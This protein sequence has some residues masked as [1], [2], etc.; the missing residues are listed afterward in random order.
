MKTEFLWRAAMVLCGALAVFSCG[1]APAPDAAVSLQP[2]MWRFV[3]Q[4]PGGELPINV[5]VAQGETGLTATVHNGEERLPLDVVEIDGAAVKLGISHY[6][7]YFEG[8]LSADGS[9]IEGNWWKVAGPDK[10]SSL[11]FTATFGDTRRFVFD[12]YGEPAQVDGRWAVT[13]ENPGGEPQPA[14]GVFE[15]EGRIV[16]GTF[17][18]PVG[19][20]RFLEG[21]VNG[22]TLYLSCF[23]GGH[24]FLFQAS[25][26]DDG[27][28]N[29]TFWSRDTWE[30]DW[31]AVRDEDVELADPYGMLQ[32]KDGSTGFRFAFPNLDGE[33]VNQDDPMFQGKV[34]L[35]SVF[36]SWCPNCNDEA[37]FLQELYETYGDRGLVVLGLAFE[38][39]G[40]RERDV[41][42]LQRFKKR[43]DL[44]YPVLLAGGSTDKGETAAALPDLDR[45]IAY[46]TTILVDRDG[47]VVSIHTGFS[48]PGTGQRYEDT[49]RAYREKIEALL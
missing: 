13:F 2:G 33:L 7:S 20:Y 10:R 39:T 22:D 11:P 42:V 27:S 18:T 8:T 1:S 47:K 28:L 45:V 12:T 15:Q 14:V 30:E 31:T 37:P 49:K 3:V 9:Q 36:G 23:D 21:E 38:M 16:T 26:Q 4:S 17:M 44:T 43:H 41:R 48:G 32:L 24:M 35:I 6:E 46:P 19:D 40:D 29:G 25:L 34:R 5:E